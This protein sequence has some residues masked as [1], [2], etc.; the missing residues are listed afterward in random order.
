ME[1]QNISSNWFSMEKEVLYHC[2]G[3]S[4]TSKPKHP[5]YPCRT[6]TQD[7]AFLDPTFHRSIPI[8]VSAP[9]NTCYATWSTPPFL[10]SLKY[11]YIFDYQEGRKKSKQAHGW[12]FLQRSSSLTAEQGGQERSDKAE[13]R[14]CIRKELCTL[15]L[16]KGD[17]AQGKGKAWV[18]ECRVNFLFSPIMR[19]Y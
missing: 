2:L 6:N 4:G 8:S 14:D 1:E 12:H 13:Q 7:Q 16:S 19:K 5:F 15:V 9:L 11:W 17:D 18:L 10:L 3:F